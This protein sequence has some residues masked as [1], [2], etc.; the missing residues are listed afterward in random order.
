MKRL[1]K[2]KNKLKS[3]LHQVL[4][5]NL[6][7]VKRNL[8]ADQEKLLRLE[9]VRTR[10]WQLRTPKRLPLSNKPRKKANLKHKWKLLINTWI[11]WIKEE[12]IKHIW[13]KLWHWDR[14]RRRERISK[15][16]LPVEAAATSRSRAR[17]AELELAVG[18]KVPDRV[19]PQH[20]GCKTI[21]LAKQLYLWPPP[22][23]SLTLI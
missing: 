16:A 21:H 2:C 1:K 9:T 5:S 8:E 4:N 22:T 18:S 13:N 19:I 7:W 11:E 10:F 3:K 20:K 6:I 17:V 12:K 15:R 23:T 14:S